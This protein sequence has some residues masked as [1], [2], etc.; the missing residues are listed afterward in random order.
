MGVHLAL[1]NHDELFASLTAPPVIVN[2][3]DVSM[4]EKREWLNQRLY[5]KYEGDS[6]EVLPSCECGRL[7]GDQFEGIRCVTED[8][9]EG[10]NTVCAPVTERALESLLWIR[11]PKGVAALINPIVWIIMSQKLTFDG[12]NLLEWLTNP[13]YKTDSDPLPKKVAKLK[14][15]SYDRGINYFYNNFDLIMEGLFQNGLIQGTARDRKDFMR[16][17]AENRGGIFSQHVPIPS[18]LAFITEKS[19]TGIYADPTMRSAVVAV[20][21]ISEVENSLEP[22]SLR[23]RQARAIQAI[24]Y[25]AEYYKEFFGKQLGRKPGW[26]RKHVFG[27]RL[28]FSFRAVISSISENHDYDE[29]HL[30]WS[31]SV[32][33]LKTHLSSKLLARGYSPNEAIKFLYEHTFKY[34]PLLDELFQE[35]IREGPDGCIYVILQR[36][37]SLTRLSAQLMRVTKIKINP[38]VNTIS[39]GTLVLA[40]LNADYDGDAL[41]GVLILDL[42]TL[43]P[44]RR[45]APHLGVLD[46]RTPRKIS[47]FIQIQAPVVTT[48]ANWMHRGR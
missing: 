35:L 1:I 27:S 29:L 39:L 24:S 14:T 20:R 11:P 7:K 34:H 36:N 47:K 8:G 10:C 33:L 12:H 41:N 17:I 19:A 2:D 16:W 23:L 4:Q 5:T 3:V 38:K 28:H 45:L 22:M 37:P 30:P 25:L 31:M 15:L 48:I 18:K 6:L 21:T 42:K 43:R 9:V 32:M 46:L 13:T 44:L 26:F 40:G